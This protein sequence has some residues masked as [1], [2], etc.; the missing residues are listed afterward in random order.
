MTLS[1]A[2]AQSFSRSGRSP[3]LRS[4]SCSPCRAQE[5]PAPESRAERVPR[6]LR[7]PRRRAPPAPASDKSAAISF[8]SPITIKPRSQPVN[9]SHPPS[10]YPVARAGETTR[11]ACCQ[12]VGQHLLMPRPSLA[13]SNR[14]ETS[15]LPESRAV[16]AVTR[17]QLPRPLTC[18][19]R[20]HRCA[21]AVPTTVAK[22]VCFEPSNGPLTLLPDFPAGRLREYHLGYQVVG[23]SSEIGTFTPKR[24][25]CEPCTIGRR[26]L[27]RRSRAR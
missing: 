26:R 1:R 2:V 7:R 14:R 11:H 17:L 15:A 20:P 6:C 21:Q 19:G 25:E 16:V 5:S 10:F 4:A 18:L 13:T 22:W 23:K 8:P 12:A 9:T 3:L 27:A 24:P